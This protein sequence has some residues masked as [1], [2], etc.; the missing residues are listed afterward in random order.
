MGFK[1]QFKKFVDA[2]IEPRDPVKPD[3]RKVVKTNAPAIVVT[4]FQEVKLAGTSQYQEALARLDA[5][6]EM[7]EDFRATLYREP[8]NSHD[9]N[10]T[11]VMAGKDVIGY[12]PAKIAAELASDMQKIEKKGFNVFAEIIVYGGG[13]DRNYG[14]AI[15]LPNLKNIIAQIK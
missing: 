12:I 4:D 13:E 8:N 9:P 11:K 10:A 7:D 15:M 2:N 5:I 3:W 6:L 1:E 14:C